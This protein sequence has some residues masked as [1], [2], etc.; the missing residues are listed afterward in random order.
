MASYQNSAG[1]KGV[2]TEYGQWRYF[3]SSIKRLGEYSN[4]RLNT[5]VLDY[6]PKQEL[7]WMKTITGAA[8]G[9]LGLFEMRRQYSYKKADDWL[10]KHSLKEYHQ[11]MKDG[12]VP[13]Q[14]D[15]LA[16]QRLKFRH[17]EI[18]ADIA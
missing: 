11:L 12:N 3:N 18:L 4:A 1:N 14:D 6:V 16:M 15:P 8:R 10:S 9:A 17:G 5:R 2:S 13:F 7:D